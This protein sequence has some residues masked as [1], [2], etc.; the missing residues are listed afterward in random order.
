MDKAITGNPAISV[1]MPVYNASQF[2]KLAID[3]ILGQTYTDFELIIINDG[4]T[5]DT[6]AIINSYTDKR[7]KYHINSV[8]LGIVQTLNKGID[9]AL[10]KYLARMDADDIALPERFEKQ[11]QLMDQ[12]PEIAV[13]GSQAFN[14]NDSGIKTGNNNFPV[15]DKEIKAQLLFHNTFI[16]PT[17]FFQTEVI[18][19]YKYHPTYQYAEDYFLFAQIATNHQVAN[20]PDPLLLYRVH[21]LNTTAT[22]AKEMKQAH[23]KVINYQASILLNEKVDHLFLEQLYALPAYTFTRFNVSVY[24]KVLSTLLRANKLNPIYDS[25]AF[26]D[27]LHLYWY[28]VLLELGKKNAFY[29]FMISPILS[30]HALT[31]K[32][33][34]RLLKTSLKSLFQ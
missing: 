14:I 28:Q 20:H 8:N 22:K 23:M 19:K 3:S 30:W 5:D 9:L 6:D 21:E 33:I 1:V 24:R 2:L 27:V 7:I 34:R 29:S 10:G 15:S 25:Q 11:H 26:H 31:F 4:S 32:Q 18:K 17:T 13:C 12:N 16:H